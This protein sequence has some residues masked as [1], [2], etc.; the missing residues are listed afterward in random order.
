MSA[1]APLSVQAADRKG[2]LAGVKVVDLTTIVLGPLATLTLASL[3]AEV[4]K[5]EAPDGDNVGDAGV[6]A[7]D[8]MGHAPDTTGCS[9]PTAVR[10][11]RR[12]GTSRC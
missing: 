8:G 3:G 12:T 7:T 6:A 9:R 4:I 10:T 5:V 1:T 11:R 2:P